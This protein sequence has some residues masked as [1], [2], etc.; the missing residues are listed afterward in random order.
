MKAKQIHSILFGILALIFVFPTIQYWTEILPQAEL[1][2]DKK[3]G[4]KVEFSS[5]SW[6]NGEFQQDFRI[7][8]YGHFGIRKSLIRM[9]NQIDYSIFQ[10]PTNSV[11]IGNNG[12]LYS[13]GNFESRLGRDFVG[14]SILNAKVN[15]IKTFQNLMQQR[16]ILVLTVITPNKMRVQPED[17][18]Q[19]H[20]EA[21]ENIDSIQHLSNYD[22]FL[23][24][25]QRSPLNLIDLN[26]IFKH[27]LPKAEYSFFPNTGYHWTDF[28]ATIAMDYLLQEMGRY[29]GKVYPRIQ[30]AEYLA[31]PEG[32]STDQDL[33]ELLNISYP[34]KLQAVTIPRL[35]EIEIPESEKPHVLTISDSFWWKVYDQ[36][37][38]H[39]Y[40]SA[41]SP[42]WY[43][44]DEVYLNNRE[45]ASSINQ[46]DPIQ[47]LGPMEFVLLMTNE[48][49]LGEFD[50]GCIEGILKRFGVNQ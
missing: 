10:S 47:A 45:T 25:A 19:D 3:L 9:R 27:W 21:I 1:H 2:G 13:R 11:I 20:L 34:P 42:F 31:R 29:K 50:W 24:Y 44:C 37:I 32:S 8:H 6:F 33:A 38:P 12:Q 36:K 40:F 41:D 18:P 28:G 23:Y 22:R 5:N 17:L 26:P 7:R 39:K 49:N 30:V 48:G 4:E 14:D 16:G 43:Y 46:V 35:A 15:R